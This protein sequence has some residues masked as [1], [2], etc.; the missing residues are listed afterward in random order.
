MN[1]INKNLTIT[2]LILFLVFFMLIFII[3]NCTGRSWSD[4]IEKA[5]THH[6][7]TGEY[8]NTYKI[9]D[10]DSSYIKIESRADFEETYAKDLPITIIE[11]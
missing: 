8:Y 1:I 6:I 10:A 2:I 9:L 3:N 4:A 7:I 5:E 11:D